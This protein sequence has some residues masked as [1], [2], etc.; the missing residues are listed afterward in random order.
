MR[1]CSVKAGIIF[2]AACVEPAG[3]LDSAVTETCAALVPTFASA[4]AE[5]PRVDTVFVYL[6]R[7]TGLAEWGGGGAKEGE[8][9]KEN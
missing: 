8:M 7:N 4:V 6:F 2:R 1:S 5:M 3:A 9:L